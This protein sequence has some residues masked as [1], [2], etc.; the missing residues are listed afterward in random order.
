M[1]RAARILDGEGIIQCN[2]LA[3]N[4]IVLTIRR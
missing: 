2:F 4:M 3:V 1:E